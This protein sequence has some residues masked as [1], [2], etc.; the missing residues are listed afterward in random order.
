MSNCS[1]VFFTATAAPIITAAFTL[2][3]SVCPGAPSTMAFCSATPGICELAG[4]A[5]NS[6][7]S[8]TT[9]LPDP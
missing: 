1:M 6:V 4:V 8:A 9:G 3:P 7:C 5:S 2:C